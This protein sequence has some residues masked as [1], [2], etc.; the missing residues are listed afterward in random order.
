MKNL[1]SSAS[2]VLE[3]PALKPSESFLEQ[4]PFRASGTCQSLALVTALQL[5]LLLCYHS[6]HHC[7]VAV[8]DACRSYARPCIAARQL[9]E[10][11]PLLQFVA[12]LERQIS[13]TL[14][15]IP[16]LSYQSN[17]F[18]GGSGPSI[19][20]T[21]SPGLKNVAAVCED[22]AICEGDLARR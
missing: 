18:G 17:S 21:A 3:A 1:K 11:W 7:H 14:T 4:Q 5:P 9:H 6:S 16:S 13:R 22:L 10:P 20:V 2:F 8:S 15:R 12:L 19:T